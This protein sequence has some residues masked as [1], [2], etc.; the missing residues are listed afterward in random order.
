MWIN[1][2]LKAFED[3][4]NR[5]LQGQETCLLND[6]SWLLSTRRSREKGAAEAVIKIRV[7]T[8]TWDGMGRMSHDVGHSARD[9][10]RKKMAGNADHYVEEICHQ[11]F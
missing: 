3:S 10:G 7:V 6:P 11:R 4:V 9:L 1:A 5:S 8:K 2:L